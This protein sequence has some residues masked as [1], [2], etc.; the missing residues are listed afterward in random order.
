MNPAIGKEGNFAI[1]S[2]ESGGPCIA[3][4]AVI[5]SLD[6]VDPIADGSVLYRCQIAIDDDAG[7]GLYRVPVTNAG[8]SDPEGNALSTEGLAGRVAVGEDPAAVVQ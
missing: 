5:L 7:S 4:R 6:N 3:L 8:A 1:V 2:C